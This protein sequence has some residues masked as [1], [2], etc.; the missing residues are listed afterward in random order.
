MAARWTMAVLAGIA[1]A[2]V[3]VLLFLGGTSSP[4]TPDPAAQVSPE[5]RWLIANWTAGPRPGL[6]ERLSANPKAVAWVAAELGVGESVARR[7]RLVSVG[8]Q[9]FLVSSL[10]ND[11]LNAKAE[12]VFR[13]LV[14]HA[15]AEAGGSVAATAPVSGAGFKA[16]PPKGLLDE[17]G[18]D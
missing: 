6:V 9:I 16:S 4:A 12:S 13:W 17:R 5:A 8:D 15:V 10:G 1:V 7:Y 2:G 11:P 3:V 18:G 14:T